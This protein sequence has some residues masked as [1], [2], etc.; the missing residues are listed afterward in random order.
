MEVVLNTERKPVTTHPVVLIAGDGWCLKED[1]A[2]FLALGIPHDVYAIGRSINLF[3]TVDHWGN[4]DCG[5]S[6]WWAE[7]LPDKWRTVP[8]RHTLGAMRGFDF[9]WSIPQSDYDM[10]DILWHGSTA[11][12]CVYTALAMGYRRVV[13]AGCPMDSGGHWYHPGIKGPRWTGESYRAWLDFKQLPEAER[14][15]S[16]S[17]YTKIIL[18]EPDAPWLSDRQK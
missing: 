7:H 8:Q 5:E 10:E 3:E 2:S 6:I 1:F 12:F 17:G 9:D 13:L 15:R 11:L 14:V 4:V 18:G 16:M